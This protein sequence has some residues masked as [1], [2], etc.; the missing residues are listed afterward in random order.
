M[1]LAGEAVFSTDRCHT[2]FINN[3]AQFYIL[4]IIGHFKHQKG[5]IIFTMPRKYCRK[6]SGKPRGSYT[7][8]ELTSA[9]E[10]VQSGEISKREAERRYSV[11][12]LAIDRTIKSGKS[13]KGSLGP[14]G[15]LT[16]E[17]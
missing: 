12:V 7:E 3:I 13:G 17:G 5:E 16:F 2:I 15:I 14:E 9:I 8:K 1:A 10:E 11:P 6:P 4:N